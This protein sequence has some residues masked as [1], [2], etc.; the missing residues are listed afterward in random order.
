MNS[1]WN[2]YVIHANEYRS[3]IHRSKVESQQ[4]VTVNLF[5]KRSII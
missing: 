3:L 4:V 2:R 1:K 5:G